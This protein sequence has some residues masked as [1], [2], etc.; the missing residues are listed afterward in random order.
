MGGGGAG[1]CPPT[2]THPRQHSRDSHCC[3][4][5]RHGGGRVF[6]GLPEA[7]HLCSC[8]SEGNCGGPSGHTTNLMVPVGWVLLCVGPSAWYFP[9]PPP[10]GEHGQ[11]QPAAPSGHHPHPTPGHAQRSP[12]G[13]DVGL[14]S[15]LHNFSEAS[16]FISGTE[17]THWARRKGEPW[18]PTGGG[19]AP[20]QA[21][22]GC[23]CWTKSTTSHRGRRPRSQEGAAGALPPPW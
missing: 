18:A 7:Q 17:V 1:G 8:A 11:T 19:P 5:F 2:H 6:P 3:R 4:A 15:F 16:F 14:E 23:P 9:P 12:T 22:S 13:R 10:I 20:G 21:H